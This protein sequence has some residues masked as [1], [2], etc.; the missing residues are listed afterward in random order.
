MYAMMRKLIA[1]YDIH[2]RH[3]ATMDQMGFS[4]HITFILYKWAD[5]G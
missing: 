5:I 1:T 2:F 4:K 3:W